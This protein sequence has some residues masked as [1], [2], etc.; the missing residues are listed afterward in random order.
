MK[1]HEICSDKHFLEGADA[2]PLHKGN[3]WVLTTDVLMQVPC[4]L[5]EKVWRSS[6]Q[7]TEER[8]VLRLGEMKIVN[9]TPA[10]K[11][12]LPGFLSHFLETPS[13]LL[14]LPDRGQF[15][16]QPLARELNQKKKLIHLF[17]HC[18]KSVWSGSAT[19]RCSSTL[20][21]K[22][23]GRLYHLGG[24]NWSEAAPCV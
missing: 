22:G 18:Y 23:E 9:K 12:S 13:A 11:A 3:M 1:T 5:G 20:D 2:A 15:I 4:Q 8:M 21:V 10:Q 14:G 6:C 24:A 17:Q 16:I 19:S 7:V